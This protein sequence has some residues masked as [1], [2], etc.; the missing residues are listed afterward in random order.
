MT[1]RML[2]TLLATL[3]TLFTLVAPSAAHARSHRGHDHNGPPP[4]RVVVTNQSG[5]DVTLS[6]SGQPARRLPAWQ[7]TE[8]VTAPGDTILRATYTQFGAER[9]LQ[10]DRLVVVPNRTIGVTLAPEDTAR[11]L[12]TNQSAFYA[13]LIVDGKADATFHPGEAKVVPVRAG[14]R[15]LALT[16]DG[17]TLSNTRMDVRPFEEP[18]WLV[19]VPRVGTL[20]VT[21]PLPIAIELVCDKGLVR[22]VGAYG[23]TTYATLPLGGFRLTARRTSGEY[24]DGET[25]EIRPGAVTNWRVDAPRTGLVSLDSDHWLGTRIE[26]DDRK[27]AELGADGSRRLDLSVG[28]HEIEVR[29]ERGRELVDTW[30]EVKPF[31]TTRVSFGSSHHQR[32]DEGRHDR[33]ERADRDHDRDHDHRGHDHGSTTADADSC[34]MR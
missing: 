8:V 23:Q 29:D 2:P 19:D 34:Q 15:D 4:G 6:L 12:V 7:T 30:I 9:V 28:W 20:V 22:S 26:I 27:V 32:A 18:R 1:T 5:G 25:A 17:R 33:D 21:N 31:E 10:T 24:I 13:Q 14:R 3:V 16:A 11:L